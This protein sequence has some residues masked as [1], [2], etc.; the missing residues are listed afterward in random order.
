[1]FLCSLA[2]ALAGLQPF[3]VRSC[4]ARC[5]SP[6]PVSLGSV[7]AFG[8]LS[9][10]AAQLRPDERTPVLL[11]TS[12]LEHPYGARISGR[13]VGPGAT[14]RPCS[15]T[16]A[17]RSPEQN[18]PERPFQTEPPSVWTIEDVRELAKEVGAGDDPGTPPEPALTRVHLEPL[19]IRNERA[20]TPR[21]DRRTD[22]RRRGD[23]VGAAHR[24]G[25]FAAPESH[26]ASCAQAG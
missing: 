26:A 15:A 14:S 21:P 1:M 2:N 6:P 11:V 18:T 10:A 23:S 20:R 24:G 5:G 7:R 3:E 25:Q 17:I 9:P 16:R 12:F 8:G 4:P 19:L 22:R 13:R